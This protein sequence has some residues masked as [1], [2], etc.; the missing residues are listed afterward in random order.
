MQKTC[1]RSVTALLEVT[2]A[3]LRC[4]VACQSQELCFM[5][6]HLAVAINDVATSTHIIRDIS[7]SN[8][9]VHPVDR[10]H[11]MIRTLRMGE[12]AHHN[13]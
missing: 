11:T 13:M 3:S 4:S 7:V 5:K 2:G 8:A 1:S 12:E 10:L 6:V 9:C